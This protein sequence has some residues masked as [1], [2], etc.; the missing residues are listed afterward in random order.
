MFPGQSWESVTPDHKRFSKLFKIS[1]KYQ[2]TIKTISSLDN[3]VFMLDDRIAIFLI[4]DDY[5]C[6]WEVSSPPTS[7]NPL[8]NGMHGFDSED[9]KKCFEF[10]FNIMLYLLTH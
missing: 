4:H 9:R 1:Y 3:E 5:G 10:S 7:A 6:Q 2:R 8:G